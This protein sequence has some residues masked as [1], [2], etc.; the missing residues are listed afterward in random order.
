MI[1]IPI[2]AISVNTCWQGRRFK[3]KEYSEWRELFRLLTL[4]AKKVPNPHVLNVHFYISNFAQSDLDN[5]LKPLL[6]A[7]QECKIIEND[8]SIEKIVAEKIKCP[9]GKEQIILELL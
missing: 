7:L 2:K 1:K 9:K 6:D 3:T 4:R 8:K 5:L